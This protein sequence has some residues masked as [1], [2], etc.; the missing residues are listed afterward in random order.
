MDER[1]Q[2]IKVLKNFFES[3]DMEGVC[4]FWLDET[5]DLLMVYIEI[6]I[7]WIKNIQTKPEFV[8][9]RMRNYVKDEINKFTGLDV[10][11]GSHAKKC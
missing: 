10:H 9:K 11:V 6:D 4:G 5:S 1:E 2:S 3:F 8:A 7:D